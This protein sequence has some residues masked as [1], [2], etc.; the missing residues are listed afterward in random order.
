MLT[1]IPTYIFTSYFF[2]GA[3]TDGSKN[4]FFKVYELEY[5]FFQYLV[6]QQFV[7]SQ[8]RM[9]CSSCVVPRQFSHTWHQCGRTVA[10]ARIAYL[11]ELEPRVSPQQL[12]A[13]SW[14]F[15]PCHVSPSYEMYIKLIRGKNT[16]CQ[17]INNIKQSKFFPLY[18]SNFFD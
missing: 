1:N 11:E 9:W 5:F 4:I 18:I 13:I 6:W 8:G 16:Y 15:I 10:R 17:Q 14:S 7:I 3:L 2:M 12:I